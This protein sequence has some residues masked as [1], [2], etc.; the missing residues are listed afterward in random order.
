[1]KVR[2][3]WG[4]DGLSWDGVDLNDP[5]AV[6]TPV[7]AGQFDM[8]DVRHQVVMEPYMRITL[9]CETRAAR[10]LSTLLIAPAGSGAQLGTGTSTVVPF[11]FVAQEAMLATTAR[12]AAEADVLRLN[13]G[14]GPT[15]PLHTCTRAT[16]ACAPKCGVAAGACR[17]PADLLYRCN[18]RLALGTEP[19]AADGFGLCRAPPRLSA[20]AHKPQCGPVL[21]QM[22][23]CPARSRTSM[24]EWGQSRVA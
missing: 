16:I 4:I 23:C 7:W 13:E 12:I 21:S 24:Y 18:A 8:D 9:R 10:A 1:L 14:S 19:D 3:L 6:A 20:G 5:A 11:G 17:E 15:A 22:L 2:L